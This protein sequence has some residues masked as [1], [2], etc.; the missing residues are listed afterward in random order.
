MNL[1]QEELN[2]YSR[3]ILL[4]EVGIGG[5]Q[6]LK[7]ASVLVIGAGGLGCP[8]LMYLTAAGVG[9]IGIIDP[10]AVDS[11]N[12][13]RQVLYRESD[14]GEPKVDCAQRH[15]SGLNP[16]LEFRTYQHKL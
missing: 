15:L 12:L 6:K 3:H 4:A 13:Q 1:S 10:D 2:R 16:L 5:Q 11:S 8:A 14:I 9:T 7:D